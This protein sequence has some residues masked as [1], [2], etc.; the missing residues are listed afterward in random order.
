MENLN[1]IHENSPALF[2]DEDGGDITYGHIA[3]TNNSFE[4]TDY[5]D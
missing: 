5:E 2:F 4:D 1:N 3:I